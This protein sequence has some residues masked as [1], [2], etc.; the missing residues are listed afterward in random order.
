MSAIT[1]RQGKVT[2]IGSARKRKAAALAAASLALNQGN[3]CGHRVS[4]LLAMAQ[5]RV[6]HLLELNW[7]VRQDWFDLCSELT[8]YP[9]IGTVPDDLRRMHRER[10]DAAGEAM[11]ASLAGGDVKAALRRLAAFY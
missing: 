9:R 11:E 7:Q 8:D 4:E 2:G 1:E 10:M 3:A 6:E 5:I